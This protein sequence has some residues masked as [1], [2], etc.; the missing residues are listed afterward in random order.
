MSYGNYRLAASSRPCLA[1][2][3]CSSSTA[4]AAIYQSLQQDRM[5][6]HMMDE[7]LVTERALKNWSMN[8][9][10][11]VQRA[12]AIAKSDDA[13]LVQYFDKATKEATADTAVQMKII[14]AHLRDP[15]QL[16][17]L[18]KSSSC[19]TPTWRSARRSPRSRPPAM[20]RGRTASSPNGS[21]P[22]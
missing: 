15:A 10:A 6:S 13:S 14:N 12:A 19:A 17:L 7:V 18:E 22:P 5:L 11:G 9:T 1:T 2:S 4:A 16:A 21:S 8:V 20:P 3:C